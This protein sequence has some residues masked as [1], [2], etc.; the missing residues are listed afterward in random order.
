MK[1]TLLLCIIAMLITFAAKAQTT[2][3][4]AETGGQAIQY[5]IIDADEKTVSVSG[6]PAATQTYTGT[7]TIPATASDGTDDYSVVAIGNEAFKN[8]ECNAVILPESITAIGDKA[9]AALHGVAMF[10][11]YVN[12][13]TPPAI[14][15]NPFDTNIP[16]ENRRLMIPPCADYSGWKVYFQANIYNYVAF[17]ESQLEGTYTANK[18]YDYT[19][20]VYDF[21]DVDI[22]LAEGETIT[23]T[24]LNFIDKNVS[25]S[26]DAGGNWTIHDKPLK[27]IYTLDYNV[28]GVQC[29]TENN[30]VILNTIKGQITPVEITDANEFKGSIR[31]KRPAETP[32][33]SY[34]AYA[35]PGKYEKDDAIGKL[36]G[37]TILVFEHNFTSYYSGSETV[38]FFPT[39]KYVTTEGE[40]PTSTDA[41][42]KIKIT[43]APNGV[44]YDKDGNIV[45][46]YKFNSTYDLIDGSI[47]ASGQ[48]AYAV[49]SWDNVLTFKYGNNRSQEGGGNVS[50]RP[51]FSIPTDTSTTPAWLNQET[52]PDHSTYGGASVIT[53]VVFDESFAAA[54]PVSCAKW[55]AGFVKLAEIEGLEYLNT[56]AATSMAS[57][58]YNCKLLTKLD[59]RSFNT[60]NVKDMS[61]MFA[62]CIALKDL[63]VSSFNTESATNMDAM[64]SNM[65]C[66]ILNLGSFKTSGVTSMSSMFKNAG[67]LVSI[68]VDEDKWDVT[69]VSS[70]TD[71][72]SGCTV[73]CGEKGT[74]A[75]DYSNNWLTYARI[76]GGT[77]TP[78]FLSSVGSY[79]YAVFYNG[80]LT[81]KYGFPSDNLQGIKYDLQEV[82]AWSENAANIKHVVFD[83]NFDNVDVKTC[84]AWFSGCKNLLTID[85]LGN[86]KTGTV[87]NM[88]KMF[89]NCEKLQSIDLS[90]FET[91]D[92]TTFAFM[93][94]GCSGLP[95]LDVTPLETDNALDMSAMFS[96]CSGL[97]A[98]NVSYFNTDKVTDMQFMFSHCSGLKTLDIT[99]FNTNNV[100]CIDNMFD[101]CSGLT[102]LDLSNFSTLQAT[103]MQ[104]LFDGCSSLKTLNLSSFS[105]E[106]TYYMFGMFRHCRSLESINFGENFNTALVRR[107]QDM[108]RDCGS[109]TF[110]DLRTFDTDKVEGMSHMF[111]GCSSLTT[112]MIDDE[113]W[114]VANKD[115]VGNEMFEGCD[116]LIGNDG[117]QVKGDTDE[118]KA[119]SGEGGYL[120][121]GTYKIF[122]DLDADDGTLNL[123][124][125]TEL[126][127][128]FTQNTAVTEYA[129]GTAVQIA[130]PDDR[131]GNPFKGWTSADITEP[132]NEVKILSTDKGNRIFFANW[133]NN[134]EAYAVYDAT[135]QTLT[136][137]FDTKRADYAKTYDLNTGDNTPGWVSDGTN[138]NIT[139]VVFDADFKNY[140]LLTTCYQWFKGCSQVL[141]IDLRGIK[142]AN[143]TNMTSMFE[144]CSSLTGILADDPALGNWK[145]DNVTLSANMFKGC[146]SL[147]T[148]DGGWIYESA[149]DKSNAGVYNEYG[150]GGY[151]TQDEYVISYDL[152]G[153]MIGDN[154]YKE[155]DKY[156][157]DD[158]TITDK[159]TLENCEFGGWAREISDGVFSDPYDPTESITVLAGSGNRKFKATWI[160]YFRVTYTYD[161]R[162]WTDG[163]S[164]LNGALTAGYSYIDDGTPIT[165]TL[166]RD[167]APESAE[168]I[169]CADDDLTDGLT[170]IIDLAGHTM[171]GTYSITFTNGKYTINGDDSKTNINATFVVN[172][173]AEVAFTG[174][175]YTNSTNSTDVVITNNG[176][177][178]ISGGNFVGGLYAVKNTSSKSPSVSLTGGKYKGGTAAIYS[179][180]SNNLLAS[181]YRYFVMRDG[182]ESAIDESYAASTYHL[183]EPDGAGTKDVKEVEVNRK[184]SLTLPEGFAATDASDNAITTATEGQ[185]ITLTYTG[186]KYVKKV[187]VFPMPKSVSI[188]QTSPLSLSVDG[189]ETLTCTILPTTG[190]ADEDKVV[191]WTSSDENIVK[192]GL[193][194]GTMEGVNVGTA[195]ITVETTNGKKATVSVEVRDN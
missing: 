45:Y 80:T 73:L 11:L 96:H 109:L 145:T 4:Y 60:G 62:D 155:D 179:S 151:F 85:G 38:K 3:S 29:K 124:S 49:Y 119:Y 51:T 191:K 71:M 132:S 68:Y 47:M 162:T 2:F 78:G 157:D 177:L 79:G 116:Q 46:N 24:D 143:V 100:T 129:D 104:F 36:D 42:T 187:E 25:A 67:S 52:L 17:D 30:E 77:D 137:R 15:G 144:G 190:I 185:T 172:A 115:G 70:A 118:S 56:S 125:A 189:R 193:N 82:P 173:D 176:K 149:V 101:Y 90:N 94:S 91:T 175:K 64:F 110:L 84:Y 63:D 48:E 141:A 188:D 28:G 111:D 53:K 181:G 14:T 122:Y 171:T 161:S 22:T 127:E 86:L 6:T 186:T 16:I 50:V 106:Q 136:F 13:T 20:Y 174:G 27:A 26:V 97:T 88:S 156:V 184:F 139:K 183:C 168:T 81:F 61:S 35:K 44:V 32:S 74:K 93:F 121:S 135:S 55:F 180:T 192:I 10:T 89:E 83:E 133:T 167:Y 66:K 105:N 147:I 112:I 98:L 39:A 23:V 72:F 92:V 158:V 142:T 57:M 148:N 138:A 54:T 103:S 18:I 169:T 12:S 108:F 117:T 123:A 8:C 1:K 5:T 9:F 140:N 58:F 131:T 195:I 160:P 154:S 134:R 19:T 107:M 130:N 87:T 59:L 113:K 166:C 153:G 146:T 7:L 128:A 41:A 76:D 69:N 31:A 43:T 150:W 34:F 40:E 37:S 194:T 126:A 95:S 114:N 102:A 159:P 75:S 178:A 165:I 163:Y 33:E 21:N 65:K 164:T 152:D 120:T 182:K 170:Y 99:N